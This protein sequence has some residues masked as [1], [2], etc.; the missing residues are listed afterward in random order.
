MN[1]INYAHRGAS[2]YLP[3][4]TLLAFYAGIFLG[5]DGIET[6]VRLS[7]DGVPVLFH[8]HTLLRM[9]GAEGA[10]EDYTVT[11]LKELFVTKDRFS[12]R[13]VTLEEF[14][15]RFSHFPLT[16]AIELK[17]EGV[18][19]KTAELL[20]QFDLSK[21]AVVTS[22]S[23]EYLKTFR[24]IAPEFEIGLLTSIAEKETLQFL[25]EIHAEE[26][27]PKAEIVTK[28]AVDAWH[29]EGLRVR[30]WGVS[31]EE[32]MRHCFACNVDGMTVNFPDKLTSLKR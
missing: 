15:S 2:E 22:F 4:N 3:E 7:R 8:D 12:D 10:C 31:N 27:C 6:D 14:L 23:R 32:L 1:C 19:E 13:I 25:H 11:E 18:E 16:F 24:A 21:K 20:R 28:E 30:A 29:K 9:T 17:G 26:L 5:A